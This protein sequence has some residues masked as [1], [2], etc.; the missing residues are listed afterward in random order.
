MPNFAY[1][2]PQEDTWKLHAVADRAV[3]LLELF[4]EAS[5]VRPPE[6]KR[7]WPPD[8]LFNQVYAAAVL[9][10]YGGLWYDAQD[11]LN[12]MCTPFYGPGG[13]INAAPQDQESSDVQ[14][15][16]ESIPQFAVWQVL[17]DRNRQIKIY[18]DA[19]RRARRQ[20]RMELKTRVAMWQN[21]DE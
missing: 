1:P 11:R 16:D 20:A 6:D 5:T 15:S 21:H 8:L 10:N 19:V 3:R 14:S 12:T 2:V 4:H 18:N 9:F 17:L 7:D 13:R